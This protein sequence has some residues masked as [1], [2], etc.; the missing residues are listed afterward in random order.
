MF[1]QNQNTSSDTQR[2]HALGV[3]MAVL[4]IIVGLMI[5]RQ[6]A[7]IPVASLPH[8]GD[9]SPTPTITSTPT[10]TP[11]PTASATATPTSTP[12]PTMTATPTRTPLPTNTPIPPTATISADAGGGSSANYDPALVARGESL[13]IS[14]VA[15]H[16]PDAH[17]LPNLGKDLIASEFVAAQTDESL[18]QFI[19]T[20]RPIWDP[21]NTSGID[22]PGKG[23]NPAMTTEDI[24]AIVA[25]IRS[26]S[27]VPP[28]STNSSDAGDGSS[29]NYDPAVVARGESLFISCVACHGPD[30][31]GL[32]NLGKDLIASEFVAA[33]TDDAL[34]QFIIT[35]R[36]I[37]DA[38]N[39]SG[40][41]MP[42]KG[43]NPAMT[44]ED[45]QAIVAYIRSLSQGGG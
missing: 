15:C 34:V 14:C 18:V 6:T 26:I 12:S 44:T 7:G 16:G 3:L 39:T 28:T 32:P 42:G 25:Y 37:W 38:L 35:G 36:P 40:I 27:V 9:K 5:V 11:S 23:G 45:I 33:Q 30:A 2:G 43:G 31:R 10:E 22:M 1:Q 20:G 17:G 13:F 29:A 24:Q 19:I 8:A 21:L 41:D 4:L